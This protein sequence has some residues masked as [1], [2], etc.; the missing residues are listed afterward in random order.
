MIF[1][2][3]QNACKDS[4]LFFASWLYCFIY[5][6]QNTAKYMRWA[7]NSILELD[8]YCERLK[9]YTFIKERLKHM[10]QTWVW[11]VRKVL[12]LRRKNWMWSI[13]FVIYLPESTPNVIDRQWSFNC[14]WFIKSLQLISTEAVFNKGFQISNKVLA[15]N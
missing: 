4:S 7:R 14:S 5:S 3:V 8:D 13:H 11:K 2:K 15:T 9:E 6:R 1:R 12:Q 10:F